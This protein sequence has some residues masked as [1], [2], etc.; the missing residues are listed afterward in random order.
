MINKNHNQRKQMKNK[1]K[2]NGKSYRVVDKRGLEDE[3]ITTTEILLAPEAV[4]VIPDAPDYS[5]L[6]FAMC[7][8][9]ILVQNFPRVKQYGHI[10]TPDNIEIYIDKGRVVGIGP[11]VKLIQVGDIIYKVANLGQSL[12]T[13][14]GIEYTFHPEN[15]AISIDTV[16]TPNFDFK[17]MEK[18]DA[19][20]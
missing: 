8:D 17:R 12:R 16:L 6:P 2:L 14:D 19:E 7:G 4:V 13:N 18:K 10:L 9:R 11:D 3:T 15:A 20:K 1:K 5:T